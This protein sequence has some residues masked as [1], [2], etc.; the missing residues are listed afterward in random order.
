MKIVTNAS[1]LIF[2]S[3]ID[4]LGLLQQCFSDV[5]APPAVLAETG[6]KLPDFVEQSQLSDLGEAFV[7]GAL[8]SLHRGELETL[9][10]A[11]ER[12]TDLV[13]V[14]DG[15]ARRKAGQMG[16]RP[17]GTVG[18]LVLARRFGHLDEPTALEQLNLLVD[19][20]GLYVSSALLQ[21]VRHALAGP[22]PD[23]TEEH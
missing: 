8:G 20:H 22:H 13:A 7:R 4:S 21:Q 11:R 5:L 17:I 6:L 14:D 2:L 18:I 16:L 10:L 12:G 23:A 19:R 3:K 15:A 9:V 1:P